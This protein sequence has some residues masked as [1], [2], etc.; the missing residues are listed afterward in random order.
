MSLAEKML[1]VFMKYRLRDLVPFGFSTFLDFVNRKYSTFIFALK[2][3]WHGVQLGEGGRI[4]GTVKMR[5]FPGSHIRIGK[6]FCLVNR[7]GRYAFNIFPQTLIRTYSSSSKVEIGDGVGAN[8]M[9][10]FCRSQTIRIGARTMLGGNCQIMDS[11]GHPL[12]PLS[13]RWHYSGSEHDAPVYIGEDVFIGLNVVVLKGSSIGNGAVIA[14]GSVV[15]GEIPSNCVA[16]GI[17]AKVIRYL[18]D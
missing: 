4:W 14:A 8:S 16:G 18:G 13:S 3:L 11:D 7:A 6:G 5:R 1:N 12:W 17:P 9:A 15:S 2:C 10:I